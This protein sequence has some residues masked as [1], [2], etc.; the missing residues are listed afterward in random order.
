MGRIREELYQDPYRIKNAYETGALTLAVD[1]WTPSLTYFQQQYSFR[2]IDSIALL[3]Q[4]LMT[5][6]MQI[7]KDDIPPSLKNSL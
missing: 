5:D 1:K 3:K 7:L 2:T 4:Q 6:H